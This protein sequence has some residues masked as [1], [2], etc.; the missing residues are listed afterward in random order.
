VRSFDLNEAGSGLAVGFTPVAGSSFTFL[1]QANVVGFNGAAGQPITPMA[2]LN[3]SFASGG[4][5]LTVVASITEVVTGVT[6][7][8]DGTMPASRRTR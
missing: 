3:A 8:L 7:G 4:Y 5:E 2:G 6:V 1:Y